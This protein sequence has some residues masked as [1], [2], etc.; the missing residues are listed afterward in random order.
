MPAVRAYH[1]VD[2]KNI[3]MRS[4]TLYAAR[5]RDGFLDQTAGKTTSPEIVKINRTIRA[6][7]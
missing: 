7:V 1:R 2:R 5:R 3:R 4:R 6:N